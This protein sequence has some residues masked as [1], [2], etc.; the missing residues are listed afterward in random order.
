MK[1]T[2]LFCMAFVSVTSTVSEMTTNGIR[3]L[4]KFRLTVNI[5]C[6]GENINGRFVPEK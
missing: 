5:H 6:G 3:H 2:G 1:Y 4:L